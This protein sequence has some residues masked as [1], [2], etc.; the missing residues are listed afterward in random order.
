MGVAAQQA[1]TRS[2]DRQVKDL[3]GRIDKRT[4]T[5]RSSFDRAI[6]RNP[7]NGSPEEDQIN[8][9]VKD[10]EQSTDRLRD[11]V[12]NHESGAADVEEVLSRASLI[13]SFMRRNQLDAA[14]EDD[15]K[16]LR[17]DLDQ[18]AYLYDVTWTWTRFG[19]MPDGLD[20]EQLEQLLQRIAKGAHQFRK[21]LDKAL[22]DESPRHRSTAEDNIDQFV[23]EFA[24]TTD[25][26]KDSFGRNQVVTNDIEDV[27]RRGVSID[28]FMK[29][30]RLNE[31]A[32]NDWLRLWRDLDDLARA[33]HL[34]W[35]WSDLQYTQ[36]DVGA[37]LYHR[38]TGTCSEP[39]A[40]EL[41]GCREDLPCGAAS[42]Q[43]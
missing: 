17:Q 42:S 28:R 31:Q 43:P 29:R 25:H 22:D 38:L 9:S 30:H 5:F 10:F 32:Q 35:G 18:L 7:I 21:S 12:N 4:N 16:D 23:T 33:Y 41:P 3:L 6:D 37:D 24:K 15:W 27:L 20:D 19:N 1:P 36:G 13:D 39:R 26:L 2:S 14:A 11:R 34:A 40:P 8:R